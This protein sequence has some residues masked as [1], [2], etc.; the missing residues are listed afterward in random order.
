MCNNWKNLIKN[1]LSKNLS[2][3]IRKEDAEIFSLLRIS[4]NSLN[5]GR[6]VSF[7]CVYLFLYFIF[8]ITYICMC[9]YVYMYI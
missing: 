2:K 6:F 7:L 3:F 9:V 8:E 4:V 1:N 5:S